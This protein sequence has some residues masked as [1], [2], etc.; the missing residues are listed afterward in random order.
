MDERNVAFWLVMDYGAARNPSL[1]WEGPVFNPR[2]GGGSFLCGVCKLSY[3]LR[4]FPPPIFGLERVTTAVFDPISQY[5]VR[6]QI[7]KRDQRSNHDC[8]MSI[9]LKSCDV[10]LLRERTPSLFNKSHIT[11][12]AL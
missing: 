7:R 1:Q 2:I 10:Y 5:M 11:V 12:G 8:L 6:P 9:I 4:K 3:T